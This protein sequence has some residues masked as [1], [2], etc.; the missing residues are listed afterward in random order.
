LK[1]QIHEAVC[2]L[3]ARG[4]GSVSKCNCSAKASVFQNGSLDFGLGSRDRIELRPI[5]LIVSECKLSLFQYGSY[6]SR[7][8]LNCLEQALNLLTSPSYHFHCPLPL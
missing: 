4:Y 3:D 7:C 1:R 8:H 2:S 5:V 6:P